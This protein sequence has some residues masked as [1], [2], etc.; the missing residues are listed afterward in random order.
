MSHDKGHMTYV[1]LLAIFFPPTK[2]AR[3][4]APL[5]RFRRPKNAKKIEHG[6]VICESVFLTESGENFQKGG[7]NV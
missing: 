6:M 2:A 5:I 7:R 3:T 4:P 1:T